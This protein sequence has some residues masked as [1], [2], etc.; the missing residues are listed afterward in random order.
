MPRTLLFELQAWHDREHESG[1]PGRTKKPF[2][3]AEDGIVLVS[4]VPSASWVH[5]PST[6]CFGNGH[7]AADSSLFSSERVTTATVSD[8]Q[9]LC[10]QTYGCQGVVVTPE[11]PTGCWR[12]ANLDA[13][14]GRCLH[15]DR[16]SLY[17]VP[18]GTYINDWA[19]FSGAY[20]Q[21]LYGAPGE[22]SAST[23]LRIV[24]PDL[25]S[26][27]TRRRVFVSCS[28]VTENDPGPFFFFN[29]GMLQN[30]GLW[31]HWADWQLGEATAADGS[32]VEVTH[33]GYLGEGTHERTPMWFLM[34]SGSGVRVNVGR[35]LRLP[36][37]NQ[38]DEY[39]D[40]GGSQHWLH[41]GHVE[42]VSGSVARAADWLGQDL[43]TYDSIQFPKYGAGTGW[44]GVRFTE[45]IMLRMVSEQDFLSQ[46]LSELRC[47]PSAALHPC[48]V[49]DEA[50]R[51]QSQAQCTGQPH[52][53]GLKAIWQ[54]SGCPE[55][56]RHG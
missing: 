10:H 11:D 44:N 24:W 8:C 18:N 2:T 21:R 14:L 19:E 17:Y 48:T 52:E 32:W 27:T 41:M 46:H 4:P 50:I 23:Q 36:V 56:M 20:S 40:E 43:S 35:S 26:E 49:D 16:W 3:A 39:A 9:E 54:Q 28:F 34:A 12:V 33:C 29:G 25:L 47:G 30:N 37:L 1:K 51:Q 7:G 6:N 42:L 5:V 15:D 38:N 22:I 13:N 45:L 53:D 31:V 55:G